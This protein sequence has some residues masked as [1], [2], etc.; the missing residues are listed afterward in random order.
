MREF[1]YMW[2]RDQG[3]LLRPEFDHTNACF[4][5]VCPL[6]MLQLCFTG[7][8]EKDVLFLK[9][10]SFLFVSTQKQ[11]VFW[12]HLLYKGETLLLQSNVSITD[13][14][15]HVA[16]QVRIS[17]VKKRRNAEDG[18]GNPSGVIPPITKQPTGVKSSLSMIDKEG[19][20]KYALPAALFKAENQAEGKEGLKGDGGS[21]RY[22]TMEDVIYSMQDLTT[23]GEESIESCIT[24]D[25]R[26]DHV[27]HAA[28]SRADKNHLYKGIFYV[29]FDPLGSP[30][31]RKQRC[32][33]AFHAESLLNHLEALP[34][35]PAGF[36]HQL[37]IQDPHHFRM[38][39]HKYDINSGLMKMFVS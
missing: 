10:L 6:P 19:E 18:G 21:S 37:D 34:T 11:D 12:M 38:L 7:N 24:L 33:F 3:I 28:L 27:T 8:N 13:L 36:I 23:K 30:T 20:A 17:A 15:Q 26:D 22:K 16:E 1:S 5:L 9:K 14:R 2:L 32:V 35:A 25:A 31:P 4:S 39:T 29:F